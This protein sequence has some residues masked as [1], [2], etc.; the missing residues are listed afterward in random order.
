MVPTKLPTH[1]DVLRHYVYLNDVS[2]NIFKIKKKILEWLIT[3]WNSAY[4]PIMSTTSIVNKIY[5]YIYIY[6]YKSN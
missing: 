4:L 5:I 3:I 2:N 1:L 6:I